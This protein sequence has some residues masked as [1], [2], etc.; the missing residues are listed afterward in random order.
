MKK[1]TTTYALMFWLTVTVTGVVIIASFVN[2]QIAIAEL[3]KTLN[4][5][6]TQTI[7]GLSESLAEP[8][9]NLNNRAI[10]DI[11][12]EQIIQQ[13]ISAVRIFNDFGDQVLALGET[14]ETD[15][16]TIKQTDVFHDGARVGSIAVALSAEE[17]SIARTTLFQALLLLVSL[18]VII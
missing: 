3:E 18:T 17:V 2:Y 11:T 1:A 5:R 16:Y 6:A 7:S 10:F 15:S 9:W 4:V 14:T 8:L 12:S 13:D